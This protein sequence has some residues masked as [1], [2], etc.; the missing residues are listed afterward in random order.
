MSSVERA[1]HPR[2]RRLRGA[3]CAR[4]RERYL[5]WRSGIGIL[6]NTDEDGAQRTA[7]EI[8]SQAGRRAEVRQV[9][10]ARA[11]DGARVVGELADAL[12]GIDVL[13]NTAGSGNEADSWDQT[14]V[15][16]FRDTLEV[17]LVGAF[18]CAQ[19]AIGRMKE[20]GTKGRIINV[21]SVHEHIPNHNALAYCSSKGGLGLL[22]KALALECGG[23]GILVNAVGPGEIATPMTSNEDVD[24]HTVERPGIPLRRPGDAAGDRRADLLPGGSR[25]DVHHR[26]EL[27]RRRRA[28]ADGRDAGRARAVS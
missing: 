8:R 2:V 9:D 6:W 22:T 20:A 19:E 25:V 17:N 10:L 7:E 18:A 5:R 13:V 28:D 11:E 27:R 1:E 21:T 23:L 26:L 3:R 12:G 16:Q 14:T 4:D 15:A 24:P